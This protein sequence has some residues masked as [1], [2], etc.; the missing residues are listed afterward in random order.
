M[1]M[2]GFFTER[3][4]AELES[5]PALEALE[6]ALRE[7]RKVGFDYVDDEE[8]AAHFESEA[9][10]VAQAFL[11]ESRT[12]AISEAGDLQLLLAEIVRRSDGSLVEATRASAKKFLERLNFV[13][14]TLEK[15]G[16]TWTDVKWPDDIKPI[17]DEAKKAGL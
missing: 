16:Q 15:R 12:N 11:H 5:K 1:V 7:S 14:K 8:A 6:E 3:L 17:W 9:E 4:L 2:G 13:E 10:E